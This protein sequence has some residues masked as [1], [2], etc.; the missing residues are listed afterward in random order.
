[1][2][3]HLLVHRPTRRSTLL[4]TIESITR[5]YLMMNTGCRSAESKE[6][7]T[8]DDN[9][10][11]NMIGISLRSVAS[12][13]AFAKNGLPKNKLQAENS[14]RVSDEVSARC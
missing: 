9:S 1:M 3:D 13:P 14:H 7:R 11:L 5:S 6:C 12:C 10:D 4:P 8:E 2:F